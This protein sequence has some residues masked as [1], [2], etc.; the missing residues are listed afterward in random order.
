MGNC[1][2]LKIIKV[3]T[4][5]SLRTLAKEPLVLEKKIGKKYYKIQTIASFPIHNIK[6]YLW[7]KKSSWP[8]VLLTER[9]TMG[10]KTKKK[11][12]LGK[13][14]DNL[15]LRRLDFERIL[16][17]D[18]QDPDQSF[19]N[20]YNCKDSTEESSQNFFWQK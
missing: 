7:E 5:L 1:K 14:S 18:S 15:S 17:S 8:D 13:K 2:K 6:P 10:I 4:V 9:F 3:S 16:N 19:L 20:L 12:T 11:L